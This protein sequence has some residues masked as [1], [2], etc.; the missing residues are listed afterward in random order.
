MLML[1]VVPTVLAFSLKEAVKG[2][3]DDEEE[4]LQKLAKE[5]LS[6]LLGT[7]VGLREVGAAIT[8]F[9]GYQGPAGTRFFSE[10]GKLAKQVEQGEIDIALIKAM[11]NTAGILLHYPAGA[12]N[13]AVEGF[14]A[15]Q[16]GKT[17]N[18]LV[19][20]TGPPKE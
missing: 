17:N 16:E 8:G 2:G 6:Y 14:I 13:R 9:N 15:L 12:V 4:L 1:Y 18:P 19:I 7:V 3:D 10:V 5:Q 20:L 11:N